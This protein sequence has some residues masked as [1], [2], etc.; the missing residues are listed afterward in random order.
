MPHIQL[1]VDLEHHPG[2]PITCLCDRGPF[3]YILQISRLELQVITP[4][5][6]VVAAEVKVTSYLIAHIQA[7]TD[8]SQGNTVFTRCKSEV[9]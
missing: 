4:T 6:A 9:P 3:V 5:R 2:L 7:I 8:T 1:S